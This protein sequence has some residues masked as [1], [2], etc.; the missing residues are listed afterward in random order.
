[1]DADLVE[2]AADLAAAIQIASA[3]AD[4]LAEQL[5]VAS[6]AVEV[7][8]SIEAVVKER[9][10]QGA[11][12]RLD[13]GLASLSVARAEQERDTVSIERDAMLRRLAALAALPTD[14]PIELAPDTT[15]QDPAVD[16][17]SLADAQDLAL[18]RRAVLRAD[19]ARAEEARQA[20][21]AEQARRWPW[22]SFSALP[23]YRYDRSASH[24]H[25]LS[26]GIDLTLPVLDSNEGKIA[27]ARAQKGRQE[28][29]R[30]AHE[31]AIRHDV[32]DAW[33]EVAQRRSLLERYERTV[34]PMLRN[35]A[36]FVEQ[37]LKGQQVDIAAVL[38]AEDLILR[39]QREYSD[40]R[41]A[42]RKARILLRR[43]CGLTG[44]FGR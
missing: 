22:V 3:S 1:M 5:R 7:R 8:T 42:F 21:R 33:T 13:L 17:I 31:A 28:A 11:S 20:L 25:D 29:M 30:G 36:G 4:E 24:R 34:E 43:A 23:G 38:N 9:L 40:A 32:M 26:V 14:S 15:R 39:S 35:H 6:R 2:A 18:R 27:I 41:L 37:A 12:T 19:S 44:Q 10:S 16:A